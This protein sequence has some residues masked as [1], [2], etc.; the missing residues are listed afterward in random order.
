VA[1]LNASLILQGVDTTHPVMAETPNDEMQQA[2]QI[3]NIQGS[4]ALQGAQLQGLQ[5]QNQVAQ[6]NMQNAQG[7]AAAAGTATN[8]LTA[9]ASGA[10]SATAPASGTGAQGTAPTSGSSSPSSASSGNTTPAVTPGTVTLPAGAASVDQAHDW[11]LDADGNPLSLANGPVQRPSGALNKASSTF[12]D[13]QG[14][15]ALDAGASPMYVATQTA[16]AKESAVKLDADY[17]DMYDKYSKAKESAQLAAQHQNEVME[18]RAAS[19]AN[20]AYEITSAPDP[21]GQAAV[22]STVRGP[23]YNQLLQ[24]VNTALAQQK[25][26]P[27]TSLGDPAALPMLTNL[28]RNSPERISQTQAGATLTK[29][30]ADTDQAVQATAA[31]KV[32]AAVKSGHLEQEAGTALQES[33]TNAARAAGIVRQSNQV[34]QLD[35]YV[36]QMRR[37]LTPAQRS[38]QVL[39]STLPAPVRAF[40]T[41]RGLVTKDDNGNPSV[42]LPALVKATNAE[43]GLLDS[44]VSANE[45]VKGTMGSD[46]RAKLQASG[47]GELSLGDNDATWDAKMDIRRNYRAGAQGVAGNILDTSN[48]RTSAIIDGANKAPG[49]NLNKNDFLVPK[50]E[51][52]TVNYPGMKQPAASS[53]PDLSKTPIGT[54]RGGF[55]QIGADATKATS[56]VKAGP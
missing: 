36:D 23:L 29:T 15:A 45:G 54:V 40:A 30:V 35:N 34:D 48:A 11:W 19:T 2:A 24:G 56:W 53:A 26:P 6:M 31:S 33:S 46:L 13:A 16:A 10:P 22:L 17:A 3:K 12:I 1:D 47:A 5:L 49:N 42:Q 39:L 28:A 25:Q 7:W 38:G 41:N 20:L 14:K 50:P 18:S 21:A 9:P 8:R 32:D 37:N 51:V 4:T 27:V 43:M 52:T 55:V 44:T